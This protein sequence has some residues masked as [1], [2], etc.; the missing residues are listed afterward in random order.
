M[1]ASTVEFWYMV[2]GKL[3][4]QHQY[5][6]VLGPRRD[7]IFDKPGVR[8]YW[9]S[10]D[11]DANFRLFYYLAGNMIKWLGLY[12][13]VPAQYPLVWNSFPDGSLWK[14]HVATYGNNYI[15]ALAERNRSNNLQF[16][17]AFAANH[18]STAMDSSMQFF[19]KEDISQFNPP[20][21]VFYQISF[22][23]DSINKKKALHAVNAKFD[24][25]AMGQYDNATNSFDQEQK[26]L[27]C[28]TISGGSTQEQ[29]TI[30]NLCNKYSERITCHQL[31]VYDTNFVPGETH[32][33]LYAFCNAK[34]SFN[35]IYIT[36]KGN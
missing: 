15:R 33:Q 2:E 18:Y 29:R 16:H 4:H 11:E 36:N 9:S 17:S 26:M 8:K 20:L 13:T 34:P 32:N 6:W 24:M 31:R 3:D 21:V 28:Y 14:K 23:S 19:D 1:H 25:L 7:M 35:V 12:D 10:V 27:L 5:Q 30:G 22:P